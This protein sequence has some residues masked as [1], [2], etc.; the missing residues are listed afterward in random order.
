[1][2]RTKLPPALLDDRTHAIGQAFVPAL[3]NPV[4]WRR[5]ENAVRATAAA[6]TCGP[7]VTAINF[8][9]SYGPRIAAQTGTRQPGL[10]HSTSPVESALRQIDRRIGDRVG[11]FTNRARLAKLLQLMALDRRGQADSRQWADRL[12][13]QLYL[14][15]GRPATHQRTADDRTAPGRCLPEPERPAKRSVSK[16]RRGRPRWR[17]SSGRRRSPGP[18]VHRRDLRPPPQGRRVRR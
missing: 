5:F 13:E 9:D 17:P 12:R 8:L 2:I 10:S 18:V 14:A 16:S 15:G 4:Y 6:G 11:S 3:L 7:L 1:M